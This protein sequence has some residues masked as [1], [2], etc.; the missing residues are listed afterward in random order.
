MQNDGFYYIKERGWG[1]H[2]KAKN[3]L[4][5]FLT[6]A[7]AQDGTFSAVFLVSQILVGV[8]SAIKRI[9]V[10][11]ISSVGVSSST[12]LA[13]RIAV[14]VMIMAALLTAVTMGATV[15]TCTGIVSLAAAIKFC[16]VSAVA[17]GAVAGVVLGVILA[18]NKP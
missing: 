18:W 17:G 16:T 3:R 9:V 8:K 12:A 7:M 5:I 13:D 11:V 15:L 14:A 10:E 1:F 2:M 6:T 4:N